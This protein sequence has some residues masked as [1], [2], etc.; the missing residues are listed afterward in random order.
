MDP[1][2][3][4]KNIQTARDYEMPKIPSKQLVPLSPSTPSKTSTQRP[5]GQFPPLT[6][7]Y[8]KYS[9]L[10][11]LPELPYKSVLATPSK[12]IQTVQVPQNNDEFKYITKLW[13]ENL[14]FAPFTEIPQSVKKQDYIRRR[15]PSSQYWEADNPDNEQFE[16]VLKG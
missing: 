2:K 14:G 5:T 11:N 15:F 13:S 10:Q 12:Q 16:F 7:N 4:K 9:P 3:H 8:N 6:S 1:A